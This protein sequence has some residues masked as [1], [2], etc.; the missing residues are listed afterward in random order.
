MLLPER[1]TGQNKDI[2]SI[3]P[4]EERL[5][6]EKARI[7]THREKDGI[8]ETSSMKRE[9]VRVFVFYFI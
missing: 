5:R 4:R 7:P 8:G 1:M 6:A 2:P 9:K 3:K